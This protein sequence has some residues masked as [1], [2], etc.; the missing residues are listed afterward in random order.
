MVL[1]VDP[2][3]C[4]YR[5]YM[6]NQLKICLVDMK[7]IEDFCWCGKKLNDGHLLCIILRK[8][9]GITSKGVRLQ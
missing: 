5:Y 1:G 4:D 2:I 6:G 3:Y 9:N 7:G 8:M